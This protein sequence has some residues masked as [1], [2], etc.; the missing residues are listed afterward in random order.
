MPLVRALP[1]TLPVDSTRFK[2]QDVVPQGNWFPAEHGI[3][4]DDPRA[5][6]AV[7]LDGKT[8]RLISALHP[9]ARDACKIHVTLN[10]KAIP[11]N[12]CGSNLKLDDKGHSSVEINRS[13]G[14][15]ELISS[16][17][18]LKGIVKLHFVSVIENPIVFYELRSAS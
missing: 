10:D 5:T 12:L 8:L 13:S 15:Y 17:T 14:I 11:Q 16:N 6:I 7:N 9:Q 2:V 18:A 3:V 4:T 1:L